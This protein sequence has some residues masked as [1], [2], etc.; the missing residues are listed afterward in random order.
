[1]ANIFNYCCIIRLIIITIHGGEEHPKYLSLAF[2]ILIITPPPTESSPSPYSRQHPL[3]TTHPVEC[4]I[5]IHPLSHP[6]QQ[7]FSVKP[8]HTHTQPK[9][10][11]HHHH[12]HLIWLRGCINSSLACLLGI[13]TL[14]NHPHT[15]LPEIIL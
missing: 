7:H 9:N 1:M 6:E 11:F 10:H 12:H 15:D 14:N 4:L 13:R 2:V 3:K 8:T 5:L